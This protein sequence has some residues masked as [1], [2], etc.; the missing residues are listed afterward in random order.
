MME[1]KVV[2]QLKE[3]EKLTVT[4]ALLRR[5]LIKS[6]ILCEKYNLKHEILDENNLKVTI[7]PDSIHLLFYM[8]QK[9][10]GNSKS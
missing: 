9:L 5:D 3:G 7:P 8:G 2:P 4:L 10:A 1:S 6:V